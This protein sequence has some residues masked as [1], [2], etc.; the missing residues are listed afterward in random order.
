ME[1][2]LFFKNPL[3]K[4]LLQERIKPRPNEM[5]D[6]RTAYFR[7][8]TAIIHSY[9]FRRLKHKTQV[10]FSPKNDHIC[11]RIEHV[12]HVASISATV[13]R[14]LGL[15]SDLAWAIG[16]GHDVGHAPFGHA[17]EYILTEFTGQVFSHEKYGLRV[18]DHLA[19]R[20]KGLNLC[21]AVRDGIVNHCGEKFEQ[22]IIPDFEVKDL[23]QLP[24]RSSYP[25]TW[26]GC[27]T[28]VA[29]KMAY[30]G[31][32]MED[33]VSLHI[34]TKDDLPASVKKTLGINNGEIIDVLTNDLIETSMKT[35]TI[36]FSDQIFEQFT[37]LKNF[38][39]RRIYLSDLL[40]H[41]QNHYKRLLKLL[42]EYL[43]DIY[44]KYNENYE[45]YAKEGN[46]LAQRFGDYLKIMHAFY[47]DEEKSF[48]NAPLDYIAGMTDDFA[49]NAIKEILI[50][51]KFDTPFMQNLFISK[52]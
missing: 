16:L 33:A 17:G 7:D 22:S 19:N 42:Y 21:Y 47:L 20:G 46:Q 50:P 38:N 31:R 36:S 23:A 35:G 14:V 41:W 18:V 15:N 26:E 37:L 29:D 27:V 13:C 25:A 34:I 2:S 12:M 32:D 28:R 4:D 40:Q 10:F 43:F 9:P 48:V 39:Y 3:D 49:V 52:E 8:A 30:L 6:M 24:P 11:T 51:D 45:A 44:A 5:K 1:N